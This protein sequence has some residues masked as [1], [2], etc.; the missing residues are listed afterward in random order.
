MFRT[1]LGRLLALAL[2][3]VS[4]GFIGVSAANAV[5]PNGTASLVLN[6]AGNVVTCNNEQGSLVV[7]LNADPSVSTEF[8]LLVNGVSE[9]GDLSIPVAAGQSTTVPVSNLDDRTDASI[10]VIVRGT[11]GEDGKTVFFKND[12][13]VAC[14]TAPVGPY[15]NPQGSV[16]EFCGVN[17]AIVY[18]S[19]KPIGNNMVDLQPVTFSV[20]FVANDSSV[21]QTLDTFTLP[22]GEDDA[23]DTQRSYPLGGPGVVSLNAEGMKPFHMYYTGGCS[24]VPDVVHHPKKHKHHKKHHHHKH[25]SVAV[26]VLP[27]TGK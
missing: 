27:N 24:V 13:V 6:D 10:E 23:F 17:A 2:M 3:S 1:L 22:S 16:N 20:T 25:H 15:I 14:D 5:V 7:K 19:N 11:N 8:M 18:A 9:G 26:A 4:L 21:V 12:I